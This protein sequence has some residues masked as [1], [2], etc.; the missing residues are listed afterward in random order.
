M[1]DD[2]NDC[3]QHGGKE[4]CWNHVTKK[5]EEVTR[6]PIDITKCPPEALQ[7]LISLLDDKSRKH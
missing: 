1:F 4:Y 7:K 5:V 3:I 6:K 2:L